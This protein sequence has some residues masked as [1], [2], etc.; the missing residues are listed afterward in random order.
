MNFYVKREMS[1]ESLKSN[2]KS[3]HAMFFAQ[4]A[5]FLTKG[6]SKSV[7]TRK[8]LI[9]KVRNVNGPETVYSCVHLNPCIM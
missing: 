4:S 7:Y 8:A 1:D 9:F 6:I 3:K 5:V 2:D